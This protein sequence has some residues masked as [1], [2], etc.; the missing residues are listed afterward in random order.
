M[1]DPFQGL[2]PSVLDRLIDAESAGTPARQGYGLAQM[3]D[4][5]RRDLEDLLN[6]R[7]PPEGLF[8]GLAE[9]PAS[10]AN[11]GLR[12]LARFDNITDAQREV[13]ARHIAD[14]I[15]AFEP[16][17][18]DVQ[19]S[20][21]SPDEARERSGAGGVSAITALYF[22]VTARLNLEPSPDVAFETVLELTKGRHQVLKD[23][24]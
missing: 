6:T 8:D 1:P 14:V 7:R 18:V 19:V 9:V 11:Y 10:V 15:A 21:R 2:M 23:G 12:D 5:V 17:L 16:R 22:R 24:A 3:E 13:V 4:A 20:V